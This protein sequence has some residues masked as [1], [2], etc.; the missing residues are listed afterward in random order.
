MDAEDEGH[1]FA[2]LLSVFRQNVWGDGA[3]RD[4]GNWSL[5]EENQR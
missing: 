1:E 5:P 3:F 4:G 2:G